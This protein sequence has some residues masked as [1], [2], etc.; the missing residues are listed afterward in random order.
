MKLLL[1]HILDNKN[2]IHILRYKLYNTFLVDRWTN[3]TFKNLSNSQCR[4]HSVFN[5]RT[6]SDIPELFQCLT[7]ITADI[8]KLYHVKLPVYDTFDNARLNYLH[9]EFEK[10]ES[11]RKTFI[12][13]PK[14]V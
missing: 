7:T 2:I 3:L 12:T 11:V 5:N 4:I 6:K 10:F 14:H 13:N 9:E 1:V 8:N